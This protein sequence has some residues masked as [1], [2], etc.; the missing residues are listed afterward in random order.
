MNVLSHHVLGMIKAT[1]I[2]SMVS[3]MMLNQMFLNPNLQIVNVLCY[4]TK[5]TSKVC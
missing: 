1:D 4:M 2:P 3:K 5:E